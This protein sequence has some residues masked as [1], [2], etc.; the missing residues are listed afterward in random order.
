MAKGQM[1]SNKEK[2]KPK[3]DRNKKQKGVAV[4]GGQGKPTHGH[5]QEVRLLRFP[6]G[7]S[8]QRA[9]H[10]SAHVRPRIEFLVGQP[11]DR[12]L[13]PPSSDDFFF[14]AS[15]AASLSFETGLLIG[16]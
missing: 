13:V 2:K 10:Q 9:A 15:S 16:A 6:G 12:R 4:A 3:A 7:A 5:R 14:C 1:R 8:W 11:L